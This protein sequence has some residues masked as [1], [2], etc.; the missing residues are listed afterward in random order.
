MAVF[1]VAA[2][3]AVVFGVQYYKV[4]NIRKKVEDGEV[5]RKLN[6]ITVNIQLFFLLYVLLALPNNESFE[7]KHS[8]SVGS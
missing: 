7:R 4:A 1:L 5:I 2:M 8:P 6:N 3:L